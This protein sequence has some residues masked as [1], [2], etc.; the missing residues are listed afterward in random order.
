MKLW[1]KWSHSW[2]YDEG[3]LSFGLSV[4]RHSPKHTWK[5]WSVY[6]HI[7]SRVLVINYVNNISEYR[8]RMHYR[9]SRK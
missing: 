5:G 4:S 9:G 2:I 6:I 1:C 7:L 8:K 3:T